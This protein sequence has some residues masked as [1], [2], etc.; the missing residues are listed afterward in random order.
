MKVRIIFPTAPLSNIYVLGG[1]SKIVEIIRENM[2]H[3]DDL[4]IHFLLLLDFQSYPK[5][6]KMQLEDH[7]EYI[8][9]DIEENLVTIGN[10]QKDNFFTFL[11][12]FIMSISD[13]G[14]KERLKIISKVSYHDIKGYLEGEGKIFAEDLRLVDRYWKDFRDGIINEIDE[15]IK[16]IYF[17]DHC[18]IMKDL[19]AISL[20]NE[21][22]MRVYLVVVNI[23][24]EIIK[25]FFE[26]TRLSSKAEIKKFISTETI[27]LDYPVAF[28]TIYS[29]YVNSSKYPGWERRVERLKD[30]LE[31]LKS[32]LFPHEGDIGK[33]INKGFLT[34]QR[35]LFRELSFIV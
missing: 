19:L 8:V 21:E 13:I 2:K 25:K 30:L 6:L 26:Y 12:L 14:V 35:E 1:L 33:N 3:L 15:H 29:E 7:Y 27:Q 22:D 4:E 20:Y 32:E 5:F 24:E 9:E 28:H 23:V 11:N 10:I 16:M 34:I 17:N 31:K 18:P